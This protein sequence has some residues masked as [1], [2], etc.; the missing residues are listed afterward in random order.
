MENFIQIAINA[1]DAAQQDLLIGQ[2]SSIEFEGFEQE[3]NTL[4]AYIPKELFD[5]EALRN[6]L[7]EFDYSITE[8]PHVNWNQEWEK[9]FQPV[10]VDDF[11]AIRAGFH[12]PIQ[13]VAHEIVITPKMSFGTGHHSTTY[14]V[15]QWMRRLDFTNKAVLDFGTGTGVLAILAEKL[16]ASE[17]VAIDYDAWS[18]ENASENVRVNNCQRVSLTQSDTI[19]GENA[20]DIILANL[21]R[22]VIV[23]HLE[24]MVKHLTQ[25]GVIILSGLLSDDEPIIEKLASGLSL[26]ISGK[27][28]KEEWIALAL[29]MR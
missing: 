21:N 24:S 5:K 12:Q 23:E 18:I 3:R 19:I 15:I 20:Y 11:C 29:V 2:L 4:K 16:G 10:L 22:H 17:I 13:N 1:V 26:K 28:E 27:T 6:I 8:I 25:K 7:G 14:Q 9:N